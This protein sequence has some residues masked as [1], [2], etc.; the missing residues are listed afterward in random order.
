L[1]QSQSQSQVHSLAGAMGACYS[2]AMSTLRLYYDVPAEPSI[3][4]RVISL[5]RLDSCAPGVV[6]DRTNFYPDGGGQPCDTGTIAGLPVVSVFEADGEPVHELK[7]TSEEIIAA[8]IAVGSEV[9]C[10]VNLARRFDHAEQ[11][12]AQHLLSAVIQRL[13]GGKTLSF[14]LGERY[15]S[16][17]LDIPPLDRDDAD[18][19][20]AEVFR[21]IRDDYP[22]TTHLCPP[23]DPQAFPLRKDP[24]VEAGILRVVE[25][26]G[27]EYSACCGTHVSGTGKLGAFRLMKTEKY[28]T[29]SRAYFVAGTR[30]FEDYRRLAAIVRDAAGA[31]GV[32]EES[33]GQAVLA[34]KEKLKTLERE[35]DDASGRAAVSE[36]ARLEHES[37]PGSAIFASSDSFDSAARLAKAL[38]LRGRVA[39]T[40]C[41]AEL[42]VA[43]ATPSGELPSGNAP[44]DAA[45][46][47]GPLAREHGGKG[48]GSKT[49]FQA[50]FP[51][52]SSL[53]AFLAV[54]KK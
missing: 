54:A 7:A 22:V 30:A 48:G 38:A 34:F 12:T 39:I 28:K 3:H 35:L 4:A 19:V 33:L 45:G 25:I 13:L 20:E 31:A 6:L 15:S 50:A 10:D 24:T 9:V 1:N 11:H 46:V 27:L 26:D 49:F 14:H 17:D 18:L 51:D 41:I 16:I 21:V 32:A 42:K 37:Q 2:Q 23:E 52:S 43:V 29:G 8:G 44:V 36:A 53:E 47:F 5:A 40:Y